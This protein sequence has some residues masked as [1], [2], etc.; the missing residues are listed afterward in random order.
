M[1]E[2]LAPTATET[3]MTVELDK[4]AEACRHAFEQIELVIDM[5]GAPAKLG[6]KGQRQALN[7]RHHV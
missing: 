5:D 7:L 6:A 1:Q 4:L 2:L 3:G